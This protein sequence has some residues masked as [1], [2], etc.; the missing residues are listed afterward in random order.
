MSKR[1]LSYLPILFL[2]ILSS[3]SVT[4]KYDKIFEAYIPTQVLADD[5]YGVYFSGAKVGYSHIK[6]SRGTLDDEEVARVFEEGLILYRFENESSPLE[7]KYFGESFLTVDKKLLGFTYEQSI[8][9]HE[10]KIDALEKDGF[11]YVDIYSGGGRKMIRFD[12]EKNIYPSMAFSYLAIT[13]DITPGKTYQYKVFLENLRTIEDLEVTVLDEVKI[14][15]DTKPY[16]VL[17]VRGK[18][19]GYTFTSF[20]TMDKR[21][22]KQVSIDRFESV[23]EDKEEATRLDENSG[24][25]MDSLISYALVIPDKVIKDPMEI[26]LLKVK[27]KNTPESMVPL[28]GDFQQFSGLEKNGEYIF[29]IKRADVD[30]LS[31]PDYGKFPEDLSEYLA[32]TIDIESDEKSIISKVNKIV[33]EGSNPK[34]DAVKIMEWVFKNV[35][36]RM[37]DATSAL[38]AFSSL[39]GECQAHAHLFAALARARGIPTKVVSGI[40]YSEGIG[41]FLYHTWNEVYLGAW[42]PLDVTFFQFPADP[43]HI[44]FVEGGLDSVLDI[45]PLVG[46]IQIEVIE[47]VRD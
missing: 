37:V 17:E 6:I 12:A 26:E 31:V 25:T 8:L 42:V 41:G 7:T 15:I 47:I 22:I 10:L 29:T 16:T 30:T 28:A 34:D 14:E 36:K 20:I 32:P 35:S 46:N 18:I 19:R 27:I 23:I 5:W 45:I 2:L 44:K 21:M 4:S 43:S 9:S 33:G 3:C 24:I 40:V 39:E 13:E 11:V 1:K 38:D